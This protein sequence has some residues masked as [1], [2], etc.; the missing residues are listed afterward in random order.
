VLQI[1]LHAE[2]LFFL[3]YLFLLKCKSNHLSVV[4]GWSSL[5]EG[6]SHM[7][8]AGFNI[9]HCKHK[10]KNKDKAEQQNKQQQQQQQNQPPSPN[11]LGDTDSKETGAC[12][13]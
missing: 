4:W 5:V 3:S 7:C 11:A 8:E 12:F 9:Q 10:H 1:K 13:C 2:I 6:L